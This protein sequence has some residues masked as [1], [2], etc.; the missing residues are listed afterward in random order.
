DTNYW[1]GEDDECKSFGHDPNRPA[2]RSGTY[3][4]P[5]SQCKG[6][7][8][9]EKDILRISDEEGTYFNTTN[10]REII[11]RTQKFDTLITDFFYVDNTT[12]ILIRSNDQV[13]KSDD[14]GYSWELIKDLKGAKVLAMIQNPYFKEHIYFIT[15][16]NTQYYTTNAGKSIS[17]MKVREQPNVLE[18]PILKFHPTEKEW[19]IYT[20]S[21]KCDEIFSLECKAVAYYTQDNGGNWEELDN[22]VRTC[23][24]ALDTKFVVDDKKFI[25]CESYKNKR[26][27]Q[28]SFINNPLQLWSSHDFGKS[29]TTVSDDIVGFTTFEQYMVAAEARISSLNLRC[30]IL[31]SGQGLRLLVS[32]DGKN[33]TEAKFPVNMQL[34]KNAFTVLKSVTSSIILHVTTSPQVTTAPQNLWGNILKSN[35]NGTDFVQSLEFANR[36]ELGFVDFEKMKGIKGIALANVVDNVD[37]LIVGGTGTKKKLKTKITFNDGSTWKPLTKPESDSNGTTYDC[38]DGCSLHLHGY[39]ERRS[40]HDAF[41]SL[42]AV[43]LMMGVGNVGDHLTS[44]SDGDTFLTRDAS[45]TWV[46]VRKGAH[47]YEFGGQGAVLIMVDDEGPTNSFLY[48]LNAGKTWQ[49]HNFTQP[50]ERVRVHAIA[51]YPS[52]ISNKFLLHGSYEGDLDKEVIVYLDL[53]VKLPN[54]CT[55]SDFEE[56]VPSHSEKGC[57]FGE[58]IKYYRKIFDRTCYIDDE[59]MTPN[60]TATCSCTIQDFE[61]KESCELAPNDNFLESSMK[62]QCA[63]GEIYWYKPSGYRKI[64]ISNCSGGEDHTKKL[65]QLCPRASSALFVVLFVF[66][67]CMIVGMFVAY[68]V[69]NRRSRYSGYSTL[70]RVRIRD[71]LSF[72]L[73]L[74]SSISSTVMDLISSIKVPTFISRIFSGIPIST[75]RSGYQYSP[76]SQDDHG[77]NH[78]GVSLDDYNGDGE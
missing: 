20:A 39:T 63:N 25:F 48:S 18:L 69:Y 77:E 54:K 47:L 57:F 59:I 46:E 14:E 53:S 23:S 60:E 30:S 1:R 8:D 65:E 2:V 34:T 9:L 42:T 32:L 38:N 11:I 78:L 5:K 17:P 68:V 15:L 16:S 3:K 19:L 64:P 24:W 70:G 4:T 73:S 13:W 62:E 43:G 12:T 67:F 49:E 52:G 56:W 36:N 50:T 37:E 35:S 22:Y 29:K 76:L 7:E 71:P 58:K 61:C 51:T 41:S 55:I 75:S 10:S 31:Q 72:I 33:F 6:G 45:K 27:S 21:V 40:P 74:F 66:S 44:Y 28:K 26:G